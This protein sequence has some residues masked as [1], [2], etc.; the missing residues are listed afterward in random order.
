MCLCIPNIDCFYYSQMFKRLNELQA[1]G[2]NDNELKTG[3][4]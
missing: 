3:K 2:N 4:K 1:S